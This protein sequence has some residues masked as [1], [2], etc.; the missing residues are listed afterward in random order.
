MPDSI[1]HADAARY[2]P[3]QILLHWSIAVLI[4]VQLLS[5]DAMEEYWDRVEDREASGIPDDPVALLHLGSG[6]ATLLLMV[7]RV[8]ARLRW[9]SPPLP[10]DM[11]SLQKR[12]AHAVHAALY[13]VLILLPLSGAAAIFAGIEEAADLHGPLVV[14]LFL[15][16]ALH[17]AAV[18]HHTFV[19]RD[20]LI[21]R[22]LK[23]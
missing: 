11:H 9:R 1:H 17:V 18:V 20:G 14:I 22:M 5:H 8:M 15:L 23:P 4:V 19:R 21:W 16:I 12:A 7:A 2:S 3:I 13:V 10:A 6:A